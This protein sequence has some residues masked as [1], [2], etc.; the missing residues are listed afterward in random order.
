[1]AHALTSYPVFDD[2]THAIIVSVS[3]EE[4]MRLAEGPQEQRLSSPRSEAVVRYSPSGVGSTRIAV[5]AMMLPDRTENAG[6]A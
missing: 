6:N 4:S 1:M 5:V 3:P 2:S